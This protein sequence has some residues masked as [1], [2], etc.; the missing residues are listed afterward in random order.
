M[1]CIANR[2]ELYLYEKK[3]LKLK[4]YS[5]NIGNYIQI[6]C[7]LVHELTHHIQYNENRTRSELETT[8]NEVEFL[9]VFYPDIYNQ[10][11]NKGK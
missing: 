6:L 2:S 3:S 9:R 7:A 1:V 10:L 5:L 4:R 11:I 8:K